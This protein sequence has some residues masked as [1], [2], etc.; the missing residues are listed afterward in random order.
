MTI[1]VYEVTDKIQDVEDKF[2]NMMESLSDLDSS[3]ELCPST[4]DDLEEAMLI[5]DRLLLALNEARVSANRL[6]NRRSE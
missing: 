3:L 4:E 2:N 5:L 1:K 6:A